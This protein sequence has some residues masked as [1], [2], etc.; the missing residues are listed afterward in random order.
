VKL[1]YYKGAC[2]LASHI[3]LE[4][5]GVPYETVGMSLQTV[6]EPAYLALNP[7]GAVPLLLDG[8]FSLTETVAILGYLADLHPEA[9]LL[10]DATPRGRADV[11][12][13]LAF[14]NSDVHKSFKPI[15]TPQRFLPDRAYAER[16]AA[17]ARG[18]IRSYFERID[19]RLAG[20]DW[21]VDARSVA[22]PYLFVMSRW[23]VSA[24]VDIQDLQN[25]KR[26][27]AR[28]YD[29]PRVQAAIAQEEG[30]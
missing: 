3:V 24:K 4:W 21:L 14:L 26:F 10:G 29:D 18:H 25:L 15:Y 28:M 20:R 30:D 22:D 9:R 5:L 19:A 6:K 2:S 1:Y 11:T 8:D 16:L 27:A 17:T 7:S 13:W 12:R 23:S